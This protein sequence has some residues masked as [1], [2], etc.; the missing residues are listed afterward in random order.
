M[1]AGAAEVLLPS[2]ALAAQVGRAA[3][4][5]AELSADQDMSAAGEDSPGAA[6]AGSALRM[7]SSAR[8]GSPA[9]AVPVSEEAQLQL[10]TAAEGEKG[11]DGLDCFSPPGGSAQ[12]DDGGDGMGD[13]DLPGEGFGG[14]AGSDNDTA[15][16][17]GWVAAAAA[18]DFEDM[19]AVEAEVSVSSSVLCDVWP[20]LRPSCCA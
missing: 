18:A 12:V 14:G 6:A 17:G 1:A 11:C 15:A 19:D 16:K 2:G 10:R 4:G 13:W 8:S 7:A 20:M 9:F 5:A 3:Q